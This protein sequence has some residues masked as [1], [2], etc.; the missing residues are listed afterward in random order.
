M[1]RGAGS[2]KNRGRGGGLSDEEAREREGHWGNLCGE[3]GGGLNVFFRGRNAH[4]DTKLLILSR[5]LDLPFQRPRFIDAERNRRSSRKDPLSNPSILG[6]CPPLRGASQ[7]LR[8][9]NPRRVS[10]RVSW[11]LSAPGSK[12]CPKQS[13]KSLQSL[14]KDCFETP[15]TLPRLFRTLFGPRGRKVTGDSFGGDSG[16][17]GPGRLLS[18]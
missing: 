8:A 11:G 7:A 15:E 4:Q 18:I 3:I 5:L 13:W 17:E 16:A 1:A 9:W 2:N 14:K 6:S 12:K 10:E